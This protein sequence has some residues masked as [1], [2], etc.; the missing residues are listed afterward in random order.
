MSLSSILFNQILVIFII[1]LLGV[2]C[3]KVKLIDDE[4][5]KKL[6]DILMYLV[7]PA[8]ILVS[9]QRD[10]ST[11]LMDGLLISLLLATL[12]HV[13]GIVISYVMIRKKKRLITVSDG[14]RVRKYVDNENVEVERIAGAYANVGYMGIPLISGIYGSEGVFYVTAYIT[15]F[16]LL[17]WTHGIILMSG[18]KNMKPVELAKLLISPSIISIILGLICFLL[19]IKIPNVVYEAL[20]HV[21][22]LNTP[23]A[24]LVAGVT[25]GKTNILRIF[26]RSFRVYY[27]A[28]IKLIILPLAIMAL[29]I[30]LPINETLKT[31]AVIMAAS[32]SATTAIMFSIKYNKNALLASEVFTLTTLLC[33]ATIPLIINVLEMLL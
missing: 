10:F 24:M 22:S 18:R 23:L 11:E 26:I 6:S 19:R 33:A 27:I 5:N 25:I 14:N 4:T 30:K 31:I 1:L 9:Y 8:V 28:F 13:A 20:N 15:L 16:N 32:P 21:A 17:I 2:I 7:T 29:V 3:Y 12:V